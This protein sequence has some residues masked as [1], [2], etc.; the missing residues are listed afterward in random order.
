M[1]KPIVQPKP[2]LKNYWIVA[3]T[4][5]GWVAA[6]S[7][8]HSKKDSIEKYLEGLEQAENAQYWKDDLK[9]GFRCIKVNITFQIAEP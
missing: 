6:W 3:D 9:K 4:T 2:L 1:K 8:A 7:I 5:D